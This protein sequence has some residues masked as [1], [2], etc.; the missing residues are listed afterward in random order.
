MMSRRDYESA[1]TI[2]Q[3]VSSDALRQIVVASFIALFDSDNPR[4]DADRFERACNPGA[5]LRQPRG[6]S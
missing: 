6:R 1:A 2:A 5:T 3:R 4:F